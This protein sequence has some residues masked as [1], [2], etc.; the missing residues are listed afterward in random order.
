MRLNQKGQ[1]ILPILAV[2][3]L[4]GLFWIPYVLWCEQ[5]YWSMRMAAA[6]D[7]AALSGAREQAR[8]LNT[9][10]TVQTLQ[11]A[12]VSRVKGVG[13]ASL[14]VK[15]KF[16]ALNGMLQLA[17]LSFKWRAYAVVTQIARLNGSNRP[18][19][20]G[21]SAGLNENLSSRLK[22]QPLKV[23]YV[24]PG[25][26]PVVQHY[27]QGYFTRRWFPRKVNAQPDH[28]SAWRV[29]RGQVCSE[30]RASLWLDVESGSVLSNGGFP[31]ENASLWRSVG[32]QCFYPQ[33]NARLL[34]KR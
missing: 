15:P 17:D 3:F 22:G 27:P 1:L 13:M 2:M 11:N 32:F 24:A 29:C 33:F 16:D 6:S 10:A 25:T 28:Q 8:L 5:T 9:M 7:L 34:P 19:R 18:V 12:L 14:N 4:F 20:P 30:G 23:V 21:L 26:P 31:P